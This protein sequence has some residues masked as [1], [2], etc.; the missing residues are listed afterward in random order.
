LVSVL[1][2]KG[3]DASLVFNRVGPREDR[4]V[5]SDSEIIARNLEN[6]G[7]YIGRPDRQYTEG[8]SLNFNLYMAEDIDDEGTDVFYLS[9]RRMVGESHE[10]S[11]I[12]ITTKEDPESYRRIKDIFE[13]VKGDDSDEWVTTQRLLEKL[14][15]RENVSVEVLEEGIRRGYSVSPGDIDEP[16]KEYKSRFKD[17]EHP[18]VELVLSYRTQPKFKFYMAENSYELVRPINR[19]PADFYDR[20]RDA[21]RLPT[22]N[23]YRDADINED[24]N[25]MPFKERLNRFVRHGLAINLQSPAFERDETF[26]EG[27]ASTLGYFIDEITGH[28]AFQRHKLRIQDLDQGKE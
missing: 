6:E 23:L 16:T 25:R 1:K 4:P 9:T 18:S 20:F 8:R 2:D 7:V 26:I 28:Y 22:I 11:A 19:L 27:S 15:Q 24:L 13:K 12:R 14:D 5:L 17:I 21:P 3:S 10:E